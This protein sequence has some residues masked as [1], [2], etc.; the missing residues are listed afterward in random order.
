M[1]K[2]DDRPMTVSEFAHK[3]RVCRGTI[4]NWRANGLLECL[5]VGGRVLITQD[6]E[7]AFVKRHSKG[8]HHPKAA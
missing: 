8:Q 1:P 3:Y 5:Q 7:A 2:K 6:Q 4:K